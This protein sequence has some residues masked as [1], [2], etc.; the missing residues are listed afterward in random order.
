M[1]HGIT[2]GNQITLGALTDLL[3]KRDP[4]QSVS[5]DFE[6]MHP[7]TL[8]SYRSF[9]DDLALGFDDKGEAP[10]VAQLIERLRAADGETFHGWKGGEYRMTRDTP[11]WAA[12]S[13]NAGSTAITGLADCSWQTV[14]TTAYVDV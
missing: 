10:T 9:Y 11:L 12:R 14:I 4:E 5:F 8:H 6:H 1:P 2:M 3:A 7:T 13:G